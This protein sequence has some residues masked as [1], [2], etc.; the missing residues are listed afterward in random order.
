MK[1]IN[2]GTENN[3]KD[4]TANQGRCQQCQ[5]PFA[6]EPTS[7]GTVKITDSMLVNIINN[8]SANNTLFF[9]Y[10]QMFYLLDSRLRKGKV[11]VI[12][13]VFTYLFF[14]FWVTLFFGGFA[15]III[16]S[17][18]RFWIINFIYQVCSLVIVFK[19]TNSKKTDKLSR[20]ESAK[21]LQIQGFLVIIG[22]AFASI[23][24]FN[25]PVIFFLY[26]TLGTLAIFLGSRHKN[27]IVSSPQEFIITQ[28]QFDE[29]L[30]KWQEVNGSITKILSSPRE[31]LATVTINSDVTAYS[32]D[33]LIVCDSSTIAQLLIANN[34]HFENNCAI[35][36]INGYPKSIF[37]TT[38]EMLRRNPDLKVYAIHDCSPRGMKLVNHLKT[39]PNWFFNSD[40]AIIDIGILPRHIF[41]SKGGM[42]IQASPESAQAAKQ[43]TVDVRQSL[44][45]E[46]LTW[47]DAG[48]FVELESF[49][50]Q[51]LIR[52]L[53]VG[54]AGSQNLAG[55]D[56]GVIIV[57]D[58]GSDIY[59]VE[60]FG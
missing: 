31:E 56:S 32:F 27:L 51:R 1:C 8:L 60:T 45:A 35:L 37:A 25:S 9:T 14:N 5:H 39:S 26:I 46:E 54:I 13:A 28:S 2:C 40:V 11:K 23:Q 55:D 29:W 22:G 36:S 58:S 59:L 34:F 44:T 3:L 30:K 20:Y 7:M 50:P 21:F 47:L 17:P 53:Q 42:F 18:N 16:S 41:A 24:I 12:S 49:T 57:G 4:R 38:M 52:I 6:F 33:R 10:K 48:N 43:L 15:N 19:N